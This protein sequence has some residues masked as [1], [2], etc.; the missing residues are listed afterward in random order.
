VRVAALYD[1]HGNVP[2][3][4]AVLSEVESEGVDIVLVGGDVAAGPLPAQTLGRLRSLG[5]RARFVMGNCDRQMVDD[6][7]ARRDPAEADDAMLRGMWWAARQISLADRDHMAGFEPTVT[8]DVDGL[9][10]ALFCHGSPRSDEET[11]TRATS[12]ERLG[13]ILDGVREHVIV[14]G[15]T[16]Q[17]FDRDIGGRRLLNAGSVGLP[18]EGVAAAFWLLLGPDAE[19]RRTEYDVGAGVEIMRASGMPDVEE[20]LLRESLLEPVDPDYVTKL[21]EQQASPDQPD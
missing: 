19:L 6:F 2:A 20:V 10:P 15:H 12:A 14:C 18:Y 11:L 16:H 21:F 7:D 17:Q 1:I 8:L 3:L 13:P 4:D 9:G 5:D